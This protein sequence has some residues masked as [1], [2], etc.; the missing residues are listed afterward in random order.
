MTTLERTVLP[1]GTPDPKKPTDPDAAARWRRRYAA[2]L[3][4]FRAA[5]IPTVADEAA[6][7]EAYVAMRA[8]WDRYVTALAPYLGHSMQEIDPAAA[9]AAQSSR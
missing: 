8:R 7:A 6:G 3:R 9:G 4:C 5:H 1:G 2:A